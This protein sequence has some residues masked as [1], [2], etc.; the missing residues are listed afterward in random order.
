MTGS[1]GILLSG[2]DSLV[3]DNRFKKLELG[4]LLMIEDPEFGSALNMS[5]N[6][7]KFDKVAMEILTGAGAPAASAMR[8]LP[9]HTRLKP[10]RH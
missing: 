6:E 3:A 7:N 2:T 1:V 9:S 10:L 5:I 8:A 4:V